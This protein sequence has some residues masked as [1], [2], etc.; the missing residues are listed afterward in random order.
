M[1][2]EIHGQVVDRSTL[3]LTAL[4]VC[5]CL[6]QLLA[7]QAVLRLLGLQVY[8]FS[9]DRY[10]AIMNLFVCL[11]SSSPR[12][13]T[14]SYSIVTGCYISPEVSHLKTL[15]VIPSVRLCF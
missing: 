9:V 3:P 6:F 11:K 10:L 7:T 14:S 12:I 13:W 8:Y 15:R 5:P 4:G 2:L 1:V